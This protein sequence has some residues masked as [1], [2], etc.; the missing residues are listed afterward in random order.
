MF[1]WAPECGWTLTCSAPGNSARARSWARCLG[2]V[3]VLAAAV[4]ALA[5]QALGVLVGE[6]RALGFHDRGRGVVLARDQLDLV[7]LAAALAEHR[8][9]EDGVDVR[10]RLEREARV[11]RS[12][13]SPTPPSGSASAGSPDSNASSA[14]PTRA[15]RARESV[16]V[17]SPPWPRD[18]CRG[19]PQPR[20]LPG[21]ARRDARGSAPTASCRIAPT[22][23]IRGG[24]PVQ[25]MTVDGGPPWRRPAVE[26]EVDRVAELVDDLGGVARLGQP[27]HV[28]RGRRQGPDAACQRPWRVV[29]RDAQADRRRATGQRRRQRDIRPPRD[30][31]RQTAG[32]ERVRESR[33]GR[34]HLADRSRLGGV[35]EEQHDPLVRR[36]PFHREQS[37]DAARRTERDRDPVDRV[38]R[39][40][41]DAAG[42][43]DLDRRGPARPRRRGRRGPSRGDLR[44]AGR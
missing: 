8:G 12:S 3:D 18:R 39:Q 1:A 29:V 2:D 42:P 20:A 17:R 34:P 21:A 13:W 16:A 44:G 31:D 14:S 26:D 24:A 6:P 10:D 27:G 22:R 19:R 9:P 33:R 25:S 23:R 30:D 37:L 5:G 7:V 32:P 38:G 43:K 36:P 40:G 4:V 28:R 11:A 15:A 35:V 41:D